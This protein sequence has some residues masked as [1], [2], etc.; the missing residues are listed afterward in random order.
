[1]L[2]RWLEMKVHSVE[3]S[4]ISSYR[5]VAERSSAP[6]W[7]GPGWRTCRRPTST[8]S[9][10][11]WRLQGGPGEA[12]VPRTVRICHTVVRQA[13]EQAR[14][15]GLI[16]RNPALDASPPQTRHHEIRP[17]SV[18]QVLVLLATARESDEEFAL[19]LRVLAATGCRR[20][21]ALALRWPDLDE[22]RSELTIARSLTVTS[23]GVVEKDTKTHAVRRLALDKGTVAALLAQRRRNEE[24]AAQFRAVLDARGFVFS[25]DVEGRQP[26]RP[27]VVTN[28]FIKLCRTA[29]MEGV[30]LH[31]L[32]H[33]VAT[34]LGP[35]GR[36]WPPSAPGLATATRRRR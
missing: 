24:R 34:N 3:A 17:P 7:A 18:E 11:G 31:D 22:K 28:R 33:Y 19:Y 9:T 12:V 4:T 32:R 36:R 2:D 20:S 30:R 21:E 5:W 13:L 29:G 1:M 35:P 14:R 6:P 15:W 23:E 27:D 25:A 26:L 16:V 8:P 10:P